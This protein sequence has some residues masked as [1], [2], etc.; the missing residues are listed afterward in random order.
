MLFVREDAEMGDAWSR[1]V[2]YVFLLGALLLLLILL[3]L[4]LV[5]VIVCGD[6]LGEKDEGSVVVR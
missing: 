2:R 1:V 3:L 6:A 5:V 4:L